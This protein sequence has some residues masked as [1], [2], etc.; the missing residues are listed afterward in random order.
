MVVA[1]PGA[2]QR[3]DCPEKQAN[4]DCHAAREF[5]REHCPASCRSP[6][7]K[8]IAVL[9]PKDDVS[10]FDLRARD[11][12]GRRV[13]FERFG[14]MVT[15]VM[16][17]STLCGFGPKELSGLKRLQKTYGHLTEFVV[18]PTKRDDEDEE[19]EGGA[20][21]CAMGTKELTASGLR[22]LEMEPVHVNG[23]ET[24]P[25]YKYLKER[26]MF[27]DLSDDYATF[28]VVTPQG[29]VQVHE[30][31]TPLFLLSAIRDAI[32]KDL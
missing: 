19:K 28:Y 27:E 16:A 15:V 11:R 1:W 3:A 32:D 17:G 8:G 12:E 10:F 30:D 26:H 22:Y 23:P 31:V 18:F 24:H 2:D 29:H 7:A 9:D 5:M 6:F 4:G 14:G 20:G 25:V 21:A 13:K